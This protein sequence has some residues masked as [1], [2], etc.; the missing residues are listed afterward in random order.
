MKRLTLMAAIAAASLLPLAAHAEGIS[1]NYW[2]VD[3]LNADVDGLSEHLD[4]FGVAGS[5]EVR[6]PVFLYANYL[7][8]DTGIAGYNV[9]EEDTNVGVGYAWSLRDNLDLFGTVGWA[10]SKAEIEHIDDASDDG[11]SLGVG[12][13]ARFIDQLEVEGG[14]QYTDLADFGST[15]ALAVGAQWYITGG[16]A[17]SAGVSYSDDATTFALGIRGTWGR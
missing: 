16:V 9:S 11:Y 14:V 7:Q 4:G 3:Y 8:V 6:G 1:W 2:E 5:I 15:T 12:A 13:R 10:H 17:A